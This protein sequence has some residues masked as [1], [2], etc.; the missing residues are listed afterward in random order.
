MPARVKPSPCKGTLMLD[1]HRPD[2]HHPASSRG[3]Y[4]HV[5]T[6]QA[7]D[8]SSGREPFEII[9]VA[10]RSNIAPVSPERAVTV[11]L[12]VL[13]VVLVAVLRKHPRHL[14]AI[15]ATP[16]AAADTER[17]PQAAR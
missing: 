3:P 17:W 16:A 1:T 11:P 13:I 12:S 15:T 4:M 5:Q 10:H 6:K 2:R 7:C 8:L 14:A 9:C